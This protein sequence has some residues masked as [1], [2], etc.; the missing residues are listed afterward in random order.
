MNYVCML[1]VV[2]LAFCSTF[3]ASVAETSSSVSSFQALPE[4][5][6]TA[7]TAAA[8]TTTT[9]QHRQAQADTN[10]EPWANGTPVYWQFPG[11]GWWRGFIVHF[12]ST[13]ALYTIEW[14]DGSKDYYPYDDEQVDQM[15]AYAQNDPNVNGGIAAVTDAPTDTPTEEAT[16][17][18][19]VFPLGTPVGDQ[20]DDGQWYVGTIIH[21]SEG[22]YTVRWDGSDGETERFSAGPTLNQMV[23]DAEEAAAAIAARP[24]TSAPTDIPVDTPT[25]EVWP[26]GTRV[27]EFEE[28]QWW[29]GEIKGYNGEAYFILWDDKEVEEDTDMELV[30]QMV[31]DA[32]T[33]EALDKQTEMAMKGGHYAVGTPVFDDSDDDDD[34]D[35]VYDGVV[36][37][38]YRGNYAIRWSDGSV[39]TYREGPE[40]DAIVANAARNSA[41]DDDDDDGMSPAGIIALSLVSVV[42]VIFGT[43]V[44]LAL[45]KKKQLRASIDKNAALEEPREENIVSY[46]D[47][48]ADDTP[49][50]V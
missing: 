50:I 27:A 12:S 30:N 34:D 35:D 5:V 10:F 31:A 3:A 47:E 20:E 25:T 1:L 28:G 22:T 42:V 4:S 24:A 48:P 44:V 9:S 15:V 17:D 11:E 49:K 18:V 8:A 41:N 26:V 13:D 38:Y 21:Y 32:K 2:L 16:D 19:G 7:T 6:I 33:Q 43:C 37:S 46:R 45:Y 23:A 29:F 36:E 14:E 40:M 39:D